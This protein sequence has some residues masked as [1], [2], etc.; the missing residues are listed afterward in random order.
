VTLA[1]NGEEALQLI[2]AAERPPDLVLTDMVM[3]RMGGLALL[4]ELRKRGRDLPVL[5][6][7]GYTEEDLGA[8]RIG[9][10]VPVLEKPFTPDALL[11]ALRTA[12]ESEG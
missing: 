4:E 11:Q 5:V 6:M 2:E 3:P 12:L 10:V 8:E 7:T 1:P 9:E